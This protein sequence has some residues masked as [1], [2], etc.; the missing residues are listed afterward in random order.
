MTAKIVCDAKRFKKLPLAAKLAG[1]TIKEPLKVAGE[2]HVE[3]SAPSVERFINLGG[4][5]KTI[6]DEDVAGF[7]KKN[8][9]AEKAA[10]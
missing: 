2:I 7:E 6:T 1:V 3:L 8:A 10:A 4:Y 5:E 9:V